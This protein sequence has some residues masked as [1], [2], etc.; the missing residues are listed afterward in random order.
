MVH[1]IPKTQSCLDVALRKKEYLFLK[2][3][4]NNFREISPVET[5]IWL[6]VKRDVGVICRERKG[7]ARR[8]IVLFKCFPSFF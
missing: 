1:L 7:G 8:K 5:H 4:L 2:I 3:A 6:E